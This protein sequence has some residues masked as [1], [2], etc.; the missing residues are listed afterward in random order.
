MTR[1]D[2][3]CNRAAV[4]FVKDMIK[5]MTRSR[6]GKRWDDSTKEALAVLCTR[7]SMHATMLF[8]QRLGLPSQRTIERYIKANRRKVELGYDRDGFA[9]IASFY[10]E[11]FTKHDIQFG[12]VMMFLAEDETAISGGLSYCQRT[13][14]VFGHCGPKASG[15]GVHECS[16]TGIVVDADRDD[17]FE[18]LRST[19]AN[20]VIAR[21]KC[22]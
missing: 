15:E 10:R 4:L 6:Q 20:H 2:A 21:C 9:Y 17:A 5:N 13:G 8:A 18:H 11:F 16:S 3:E 19:L 7:G 1:G 12:S 14:R 22:E